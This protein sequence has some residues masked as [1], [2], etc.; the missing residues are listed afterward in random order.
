MP[1]SDERPADSLPLAVYQSWLAQP[2]WMT[3]AACQYTDPDLFF[4]EQEGITEETAE[5]ASPE[6]S[7]PVRNCRECGG[8][9]TPRNGRQ[10]YC[11]EPCLT[12]G[13]RRRKRR[14]RHR[15]TDTGLSEISAEQAKWICRR[16][17]VIAQCLDYAIEHFERWGIWGGMTTAE[18]DAESDKRAAKKAA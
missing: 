17:P 11:S 5:L 2:A 15:L 12:E 14:T 9:F 3:D 10:A 6:A 13:T 8:L 1:T 7:G 4:P 16:C 18:R